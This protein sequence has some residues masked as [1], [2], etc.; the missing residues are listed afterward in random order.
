MSTYGPIITPSQI[1]AN[2]DPANKF[3]LPYTTPTATVSPSTTKVGV[4]AAVPFITS[5]VSMLLQQGLN[6]AATNKQN[7]YNSPVAQMA[8][9]SAAGINPYSAVSQISGNNTSAPYRAADTS[10]IVNSV[11]LGQQ[12]EAQKL[13]NDRMKIDNDAAALNLR[14]QRDTYSTKL[15]KFQADAVKAY[16]IAEVSKGKCTYQEAANRIKNFEAEYQEWYNKAGDYQF[17]ARDPDSGVMTEYYLSKSP[18]QI[19]EFIL[20]YLTGQA[21]INNIVSRTLGQGIMNARNSVARTFE[22]MYQIPFNNNNNI[23][24]AL[25]FITSPQF[26]KAIATLKEIWDNW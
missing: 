17:S 14:Y 21:N 1:Q 9:L 15:K 16:W 7:A 8:R 10:N 19:Q 2:V 6:D 23:V 5:I 11:M 20:P 12:L 18:R 4:A 13:Q 24:T 25:K 26:K 3:V 22:E